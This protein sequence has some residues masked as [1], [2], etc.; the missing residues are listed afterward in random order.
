MEKRLSRKAFGKRLQEHV[1][2]QVEHARGEESWNSLS[3]RTGIPWATLAGQ[4]KKRSYSLESLALIARATGRHPSFFFPDDMRGV[5]GGWVGD[6]DAVKLYRE[7]ER[8]V[9]RGRVEHGVTAGV[10]GRDPRLDESGEADRGGEP[11]TEATREPH[12]QQA[13]ERHRRSG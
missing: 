3:E 7:V 6:D 9:L 8:L 10:E 11:L 12:H 5:P 2:R 13:P 4:V 1:H